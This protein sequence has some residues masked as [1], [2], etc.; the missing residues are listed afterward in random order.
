MDEGA[1][2]RSA[3]TTNSRSLPGI[4]A[5]A[6][7]GQKSARPSSPGQTDGTLRAAPRQMLTLPMATAEPYMPVPPSA[8]QHP[9]TTRSATTG[10]Q[11]RRRPEPSVLASARAA[12][13]TRP[14]SL[15][16]PA[17]V[18]APWDSG[19][20]QPRRAVMA[21]V[22]DFTAAQSFPIYERSARPHTVS[23]VLHSSR[24]SVRR[25]LSQ[26]AATASAAQDVPDLVPHKGAANASSEERPH[27]YT[28]G[29][30]ERSIEVPVARVAPK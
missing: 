10:R 7:V 25:H 20:T 14:S 5:R 13:R 17:Y 22:S 30:I 2:L 4:G 28:F 15:R 24:E 18:D 16:V 9:R 12:R 8:S 23:N 11:V 1:Q 29:H 27:V 3:A 26:A 21:P 19:E 6:E